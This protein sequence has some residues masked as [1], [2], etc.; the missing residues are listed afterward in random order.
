[1]KVG[2]LVLGNAREWGV[3]GAVTGGAGLI[4]GAMAGAF[5]GVPLFVGLAF[6]S[7]KAGAP[8]V[9]LSTAGS[10]DKKR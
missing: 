10:G 7:A 2:P 3:W 8:M 1:M 4:F 6:T 5:V 9:Q